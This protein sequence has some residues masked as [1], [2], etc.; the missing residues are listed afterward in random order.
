MAKI[1]A[2]QQDCAGLRFFSIDG[3]MH[4]AIYFFR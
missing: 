3:Y 4:P 2:L 1:E